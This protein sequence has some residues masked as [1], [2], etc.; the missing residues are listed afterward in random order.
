MRGYVKGDSIVVMVVNAGE[1]DLYMNWVCSCQYNNI[2]I[3]N[4][5]V[6]AGSA[7]ITATIEAS[8]AIAIYD[9][10]FP[11]VS[12]DSYLYAHNG[13]SYLDDR[14]YMLFFSK[15]CVRPYIFH[16]CWTIDKYPIIQISK[17]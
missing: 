13:S 14:P 10:S 2:S 8:G 11:A 6:L 9:K 17:V 7:D 4:T 1:V 16:M 5:L 15:G 12:R 3:S